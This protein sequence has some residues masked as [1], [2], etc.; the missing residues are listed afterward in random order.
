M[1]IMNLSNLH[2]QLSS[3]DECVRAYSERLEAGNAPWPHV[4]VL[5]TA[6]M[7]WP[8]S[9]NRSNNFVASILARLGMTSESE[10][11]QPAINSPANII[12][13]MFGGMNAVVSAALDQLSA[14]ISHVQR[15]WLLVA[16]V[17]QVIVDMAFHFDRV[18]PY[19]RLE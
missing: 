3:A 11:N 17:F 6:Y 5:L 18:Q 8:N 14:E 15:R 10:A 4:S 2:T 16:D 1:P 19:I 7:A 12:F 9:E 13:Q